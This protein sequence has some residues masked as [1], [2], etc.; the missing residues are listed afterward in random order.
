ML[1]PNPLK[2][3][4]FHLYQKEDRYQCIYWMVLELEQA[5]MLLS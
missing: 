5:Y 1:S 3:I 2:Y 4:K